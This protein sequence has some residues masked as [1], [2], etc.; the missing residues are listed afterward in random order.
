[1]IA[2]VL[3]CAVPGWA[4]SLAD[5]V[6]ADREKPKPRARK[7]ITDDNLKEPATAP[8]SETEAAKS[9]E[10]A[11]PFQRELFRMRNVL[12]DICAD[13]RT[14]QGR[15]LSAEDKAAMT[16]GVKPLRVRAREFEKR[17]DA[18]KN[19]LATLDQEFEAKILKV[20]H[21]AQPLTDADIQRVKAMRDEHDARRAVLIKQAESEAEAYKAFQQELEPVADECPAAA[22]SVPD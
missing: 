4:Q 19:A 11:D 7:V 17:G 14:D 10:P 22:A 21:T 18:S 6:R 5:L 2:A 9:Q 12:H 20:I 3:V 1:V 13:P 15:N 16:E 8:S